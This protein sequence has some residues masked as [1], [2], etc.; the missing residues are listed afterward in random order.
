MSGPSTYLYW[1]L[2]ILPSVCAVTV[3]GCTFFI[4]SYSDCSE[5]RWFPFPLAL[6]VWCFS[7]FIPHSCEEKDFCWIDE[8]F[9][10][11]C[12]S[13]QAL[14]FAHGFSLL[15]N[16]STVWRVLWEKNATANTWREC[17][18]AKGTNV[19][20]RVYSR[21]HIWPLQTHWCVRHLKMV[22]T[23]SKLNFTRFLADV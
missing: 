22:N 18:C 7:S 16:S 12:V 23:Q 21:C 9:N 10:T 19:N 17:C 8:R 11:F 13:H 4:D 20:M 6:F 2:T 3:I 1:N 14:L 5:P 15:R